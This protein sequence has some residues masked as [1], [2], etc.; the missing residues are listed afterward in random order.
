[1]HL[2][3]LYFLILL[4]TTSVYILCNTGCANMV[5]PSGG[6]KD[7]LPPSIVS[8]HPGNKSLHF[9]D[10]KIVFKFDEFVDLNEV[11]KNLLFSPLPKTFP[12]V[13][14]KLKT[15]TIKYKDTLDENTTYSIN[16]KDAVKDLNEGNKMKDIFYVFSTGAYID[17][18]QLSGNIKLA[19]TGNPDSTLTV[20][21]YK[22]LTDSAIV[23]EKPNYIARLDS[24]GDFLFRNLPPGKYKLYALKDESGMY[25]YTNKEALF[26]FVDSIIQIDTVQH[27]PIKMY[28]YSAEEKVQ[29]YEVPESNKK[30]KRIKYST[31]LEG[32]KQSLLDAFTIKF[33]APIKTWDSTKVLFSKDSIYTPIKN[34]TVKL[35]S[36]HLNL[37]LNFKWDTATN[38]NIVLAKDFALDSSNRQLLKPDTIHF[39]TKKLEDYGQAILTF[40]GLENIKN[41]VF[42]MMQNGVVKNSFPLKSK[43]L[44]IQLYAPGEYEF[45]ILQDN[46]GNGVWDP[47]DFFGKRTQP[48]RIALFTRKITIKSNWPS[49]IE[50]VIDPLK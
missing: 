25:R 24:V 37:T 36:A 20:M 16:F 17:S 2:R 11:R 5:P 29:V 39:Q 46:N 49:E 41:P 28:A 31:N 50:I 38:Y 23:K 1:M 19:K 35:D 15:I 4:C 30:E 18:L 42:Q 33:E 12:D 3:G 10:K 9:K 43:K 34:Y 27:A 44:D 8:V 7:T 6:P 14:R 45:Q 48:E 47:G 21:L 40:K 32:D 13:D 22:N 26:A